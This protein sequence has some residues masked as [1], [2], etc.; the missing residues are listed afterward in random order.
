M[1]TILNR[2][3]VCNKPNALLK[4]CLIKTGLVVPDFDPLDLEFEEMERSRASVPVDSDSESE[5]PYVLSGQQVTGLSGPT[6]YSPSDYL[7]VST[8]TGT[9]F[10]Q[11][12]MS[13]YTT[14]LQRSTALKESLPRDTIMKLYDTALSKLQLESDPIKNFAYNLFIQFPPVAGGSVRKGLVVISLFHSL[15]VMSLLTLTN[16][17]GFSGKVDT[18]EAQRIFQRTF[19]SYQRPEQGYT[20]CGMNVS[21]GT[22]N[23]ILYIINSLKEQDKVVNDNVKAAALYYVSN[24]TGNK[25]IYSD[26]VKHCKV[27][28]GTIRPIV[29][30][31]MVEFPSILTQQVPGIYQT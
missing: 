26:L 21:S 11:E 4:V 12:G 14:K 27:C 16:Y 5:D 31:L 18:T 20:F 8:S 7:N 13:T 15:P 23:L 10:L 30:R 29:K 17:F 19:P 1:E 9:S 22:K 2:H 28:E 25:I 6:G 3:F 24:A